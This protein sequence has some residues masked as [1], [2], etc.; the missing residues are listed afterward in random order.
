[1]AGK[2]VERGGKSIRKLNRSSSPVGRITVMIIASLIVLPVVTLLCTPLGDSPVKT[3][4]S[5]KGSSTGEM[6]VEVLVKLSERFSLFDPEVENPV[7]YR[8][9][10]YFSE[11]LENSSQISL[12]LTMGSVA[13]NATATYRDG[14]ERTVQ[15]TIVPMGYG[16]DTV[17]IFYFE[18]GLTGFEIIIT[19][20]MEGLSLLGRN[21]LDIRLVAPSFSLFIPASYRIQI[22]V[23][24]TLEVSSITSPQV[25]TLKP[26]ETLGE[27][28]RIYTLPYLVSVTVYYR[29]SYWLSLAVVVFLII[30]F[31]A[32]LLSYFL[33]RTPSTR[34]IQVY[35]KMGLLMDT[36]RCNLSVERLFTLYMLCSILMVSLSLIAG[37]DPRFKVYAVATPYSA[38]ALENA[39]SSI[40]GPTLV[41]SPQDTVSEFETM[42][43]LGVV[44]TVFISFYPKLALD[45]VVKYTLEA[46]GQVELIVIDEYMV[47]P[48]LANDLKLRYKEKVVSIQGFD[49]E[50]IRQISRT[51]RGL[52][53][54]NPFGLEL[55]TDLFKA[56]ATLV[57]ILSFLTVSF[58]LAFLSSRLIDVSRSKGI[59]ALPEAIMLP[60]FVFYFTQAIY[61]ATSVLLAM[62]VGLHAVTSGSREITVVGLLGFG[63]GSSP[64][65]VSG[66]LGIILGVLIAIKGKSELD[67]WG[68]VVFIVSASF[69]IIDPFTGGELFYDAMLFFLS[70][71]RSEIM[72]TSIV[73]TKDI[74]SS[75]GRVFGGWVTG[76]YGL[77][78]GEILFYAAAIPIFLFPTLKR[79]TATFLILI[80]SL[81]AGSG[82]IRTAEMTPYKTVASLIPGIAV[83]LAVS[84]VFI[85]MSLV[86]T[87]VRRRL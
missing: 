39:L 51:L 27:N 84:G 53:A 76:I 46:M 87:R 18:G 24:N 5:L 34:V 3:E 48:E 31:G 40:I 7:L 13:F 79:S 47:D 78:T 11:P 32:V 70:G 75:M 12:Y 59:G 30:V 54:K 37:P 85:A 19:G 82:F 8:V 71:P 72:R 61:M 21:M 74:L 43:N 45:R 68:I 65:A 50:S 41:I 66:V 10:A 67:R 2:H 6:R 57:A 9:S 26:E 58:G 52:R 49:Q 29:P 38:S 4:D 63:G 25:Q 56:V 80:C 28:S 86:E 77:S 81:A 62:P 23:P 22:E 14:S 44:K 55:Q 60:A 35:E 83:G 42:A 64:R 1:M 73:Y 16:V 36:V 17:S 33:G 20:S 69:L 15:P